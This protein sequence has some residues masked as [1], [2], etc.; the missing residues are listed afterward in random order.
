MLRTKEFVLSLKEE[1]QNSIGFPTSK[2][3]ANTKHS[4]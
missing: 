2:L 3:P 4:L 1:Q